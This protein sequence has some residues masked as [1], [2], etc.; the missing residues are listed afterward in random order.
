L[1]NQLIT[2][3]SSK[4]KFIL[5]DG[6][7]VWLNANSKLSY[8]AP[9]QENKRIVALEGEGFFEVVR[10]KDKLF[11]VRSGEINIEVLGTSFDVS[12]YSS[13]NIIETVLLEG[14]IKVTSEAFKDEIILKPNQLLSYN[15]AENKAAIRTAKAGLYVDWIKERLLFDND[16]LADIIISMEGWY[17]VSIDCPEAFA[18]NTR[19]SFTVRGESIDEIMKAMSFIIPIRYSIQR[20]RVKI[21]PK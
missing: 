18:K 9:F 15:K 10:D 12:N 13:D 1:H 5:P 16:C 7:S 3:P 19:L 20:D 2:A 6:S 14:S 8:T 21:I 4:G 11:I 17:N